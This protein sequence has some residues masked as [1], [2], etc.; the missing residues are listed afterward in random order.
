MI[1]WFQSTGSGT[2]WSTGS[3]AQDFLCCHDFLVPVKRPGAGSGAKDTLFHHDFYGSST[4]SAAKEILFHHDFL[5]SGLLVPALKSRF[6]IMISWVPV[7]WFWRSRQ[8]PF[9]VMISWVPVYWSWR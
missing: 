7:Y 6:A 3:G 9:A 8:I 4:G 1:C 5:G 2:Y